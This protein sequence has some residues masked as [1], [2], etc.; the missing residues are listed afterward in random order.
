MLSCVSMGWIQGRHFLRDFMMEVHSVRQVDDAH[1]VP[2]CLE[3][4]LAELGRGKCQKEIAREQPGYFARPDIGSWRIPSESW[5]E[6]FADVLRR[7]GL[8]EVGEPVTTVHDLPASRRRL[9]NL[10]LSGFQILIFYNPC[11]QIAARFA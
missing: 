11:P 10:R 5:M 4:I 6:E 1:S 8:L 9:E 2:A 3:G 7:L